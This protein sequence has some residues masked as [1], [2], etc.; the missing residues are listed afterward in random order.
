MRAG[1]M[2]TDDPKQWLFFLIAAFAIVIIRLVADKL[3]RDRIREYVES[4]GGKVREI[5]WNPFGP[6]WLGSRERIYDVEY[7]TKQ[8][9]TRT[10][11][12]KTSMF[13]GVYWTEEDS[14][15]EPAT[16][17]E[18]ITCLAC[19][20]KIPAQASHCPTCGWSYEGK[21]STISR[22]GRK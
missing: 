20:T 5:R 22:S 6:G 7:Q 18:P 19:G 13:S 4:R 21:A 16:R 12:C 9:T 11:T 17:A 15:Q 2:N 3:D 8:G 10:H 14:D 1:L